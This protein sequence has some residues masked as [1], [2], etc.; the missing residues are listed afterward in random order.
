MPQKTESQWIRPIREYLAETLGA[1][2]GKGKGAQDPST[3]ADALLRDAVNEEA[4]DIH[5]S[6]QSQVVVVRFRVD[7]ALYDVLRMPADEGARLV[8]HLKTMAELDAGSTFRPQEAR[9]SYE[10]D[11]R[12]IDLRLAAVPTICGGKMTIRILDAARRAWRIGELGMS[13]EHRNILASWLG[14]VSGMFLVTG[15]TGSGKTTTLYALLHELKLAERSVITI[16]DP[17]EY[18]IDGVAQ[19][20]VDRR[21]G[22]TFAEGLRTILRLDPDY[23]LVGE[24]RDAESAQAAME[25]GSIGHPL[26]STLHSRD[27]VGAVTSL[28][29]WEL[30][31]H[32]IASSLEVVVAQR[33]VGL[34][35]TDCRQLAAPTDQEAQWLHALGLPV[36]PQTWHAVGCAKCRNL[37][38]RGRSGV[39]EVWR[40]Q[41]QDYHLILGQADERT[42]R[43]H[44][45]SRGHMPI[46]ADGLAMVAD[47]KTSLEQLQ[48]LG[49]IYLPPPKTAAAEQLAAHMLALSGG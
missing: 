41:E 22:L 26:M 16:E 4:S 23:V 1:E 5:I 28:R 6:Y 34:L 3:W 29:N 24:I 42:L 10:V 32:E 20:Q 14:A 47:G 9:R 38:Y 8:R 25:A 18:Q 2:T 43:E 19:V 35:C 7:G 44:L 21:R 15:P 17:V 49:S 36:P 13:E 40:L 31:D 27:A 39:F 33:L 48:T 37:G 11:G 12:E 46:L 45:A 30:K